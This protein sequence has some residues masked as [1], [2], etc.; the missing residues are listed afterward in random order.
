MS[1]KLIGFL[2]K[3]LFEI[4]LQTDMI[5]N[6]LNNKVQRINNLYLYAYFRN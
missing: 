4:N 1:E 3:K 6:K 2:R 5:A